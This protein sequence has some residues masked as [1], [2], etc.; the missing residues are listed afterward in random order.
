MI[1]DISK[2]ANNDVYNLLIGLG[3]SHDLDVRTMQRMLEKAV[4]M[5]VDHSR[6]SD[7]Q[8]RGVVPP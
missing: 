3:D 4:D 7:A 6:N 2:T 5:P 8:R 1:F